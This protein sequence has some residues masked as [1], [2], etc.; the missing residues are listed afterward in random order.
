M[1]VNDLQESVLVVARKQ[2]ERLC[3]HVFSRSA[4]AVRAAILDHGCFLERSIAEHDFTHK[5]AIPYVVIQHD[6]RFLLT[7]RTRKQTESRLHDKF[8]LGI[9]GHINNLDLPAAAGS[10]IIAAGMKRELDEE[11]S[12]PGAQTIRLVGV[13]ND[14]ST[15]VARVHLGLVFMLVTDSAD[16][17]VVE[18]DKFTAQW[19]GPAELEAHYDRMESWS[20]IIYDHLIAADAGARARKWEVPA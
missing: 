3:P 18:R 16:F 2:I 7:R 20:Q 6:E 12:L 9:G 19:A 5:Q 17:T 10:D 15:E 13:I 11:I 14:D 4:G 1:N 8:S